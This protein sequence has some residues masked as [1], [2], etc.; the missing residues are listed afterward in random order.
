L[1]GLFAEFKDEVLR[2]F[3]THKKIDDG[4]YD[5]S[6]E[7]RV[8]RVYEKIEH[9]MVILRRRIVTNVE[10]VTENLK[11]IKWITENPGRQWTS[12]INP[13]IADPREWY[14]DPTDER[15]SDNYK[16]FRIGF[17]EYE[18]TLRLLRKR[19]SVFRILNRDLVSIV[20]L[21]FLKAKSNYSP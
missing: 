14:N 7:D 5:N 16:P 12:S 3:E 21:K 9:I 4:N 18:M 1:N 8:R 11:E 13:I 15:F 17:P 2:I 10:I 19:D 6:I 20:V